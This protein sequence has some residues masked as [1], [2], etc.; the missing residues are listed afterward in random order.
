[1]ICTRPDVAPGSD[2]DAIRFRAAGTSD[3]AK[4]SLIGRPTICAADPALSMRT[5]AGFTYAATPSWCTQIAFGLSSTSSRYRSVTSASACSSPLPTAVA[6]PTRPPVRGSP[7]RRA[8]NRTTRRCPSGISQGRS[9]SSI[10]LSGATRMLSSN[11]VTN[12]T[13]RAH[14]L[15]SSASGIPS[16]TSSPAPHEA[17]SPVKLDDHQVPSLSDQVEPRSSRSDIANPPGSSRQS[18][19]HHVRK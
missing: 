15:S 1:M 18:I 16:N 12:S 3:S 7:N 19:A 8:R 11:G 17:R 10:C 2:R 5:A 6:I 9:S 14:S 13:R 4:K